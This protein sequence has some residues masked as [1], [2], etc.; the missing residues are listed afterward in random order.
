MLSADS[1]MHPGQ[2]VR[3]LLDQSG[4]S[5]IDAAERL[6][7]SRQQLTRLLGQKSGLSPEMALR[8]ES[9]FGLSAKELLERQIDFELAQTKAEAGRALADLEPYRGPLARLNKDYVF[10]TL[11]AHKAELN[12]AGIEHL[13]LFGSIARGEAR[14]SSDV[15]LFYTPAPSAR[16]G[17]LDLAKLNERIE[18]ILGLKVDLVPGDS[19]RP[20]IKENVMRD[21]IEVF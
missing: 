21:A 10:D 13:F 7:V 8:L 5:V 16:I 6:H 15:D 20:H 2:L 3:G 9:V 12:A 19:F 14:A 17:L 11:R 1:T 18:N 4:L